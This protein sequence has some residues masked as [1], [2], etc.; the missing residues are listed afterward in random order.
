MYIYDNILYTHSSYSL[1]YTPI[2]VKVNSIWMSS[3]DFFFSFVFLGVV[4]FSCGYLWGYIGLAIS[5]IISLLF[6]PSFLIALFRYFNSSTYFIIW[7]PHSFIYTLIIFLL[8][9]EYFCFCIFIFMFKS[10]L[11]IKLIVLIRWSKSSLFSKIKA[12]SSVKQNILFFILQLL[13]LNSYLL[14]SVTSW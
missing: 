7:F 11:N 3:I 1:S 5:F 12:M 9:N 13:F 14:L 4:E 6:L 2:Y 8:T 10:L